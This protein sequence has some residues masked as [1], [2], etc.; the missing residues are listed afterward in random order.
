MKNN[1]ISV[2]DRLPTKDTECLCLLDRP[3]GHLIPYATKNR[4]IIIAK[5]FTCLQ[6]FLAH[7]RG[8]VGAKVLY[9]QPIEEPGSPAEAK[10][11][12]LDEESKPK[13]WHAIYQEEQLREQKDNK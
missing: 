5:Y 2:D 13:N 12:P 6:E 11:F 7:M 3:P 9:W 8:P 1:W 4:W 10:F